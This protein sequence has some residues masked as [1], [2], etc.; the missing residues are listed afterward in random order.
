[1]KTKIALGSLLLTACLAVSPL[2][3][4]A[5]DEEA[6]TAL[7]KENGCLKCHDIT[8]TKKGPAYKKVAAKYKD[9]P[10]AE[11]KQKLLDNVTKEPMV[12]LEDGSKE[13]HKVIDT[14]DPKQLDNL[15]EFILTR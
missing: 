3:G 5:V 6:A 10:R 2:A 4:A 14:K 11:A 15:F 12:E 13:K 1:M 9:K 8:R 7:L